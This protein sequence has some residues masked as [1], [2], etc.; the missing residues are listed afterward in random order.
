MTP[1][2]LLDDI[3]PS[4]PSYR[5]GPDETSV[6]TD[7]ISAPSHSCGLL[8]AHV[9]SLEEINTRRFHLKVRT[10]S[11]N[12]PISADPREELNLPESFFNVAQRKSLGFN[13]NDE[14]IA[15]IIKE[16]WQT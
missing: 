4:S 7:H 12:E 5:E 10:Y 11:Q 16:P 9:C 6:A 1:P 2:V 13:D 3:Q 15:A 8:S 14:M